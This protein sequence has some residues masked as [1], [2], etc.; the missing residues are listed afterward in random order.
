MIALHFSKKYQSEVKKYIKGNR[1]NFDAVKKTLYLFVQNQAHPSLHV[2][3][4][5]GS[6]CWTIRLNS[7][8]RI[9]FLWID[10]TSVLFV[11]IGPH[12]KYRQY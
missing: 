12:D 1:K 8:D 5:K 2:E 10:K 9:F 4:L 11:D 3:K 7:G 6:A